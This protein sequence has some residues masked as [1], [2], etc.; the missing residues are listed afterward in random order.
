MADRIIEIS[1]V[2]LPSSVGALIGAERRLDE[3]ES[4]SG[5]VTAGP[6]VLLRPGLYEAAVEYALDAPDHA[7]DSAFD[8]TSAPPERRVIATGVLAPTGGRT[9]KSGVQITL[10]D[11]ARIGVRTYFA[12]RGTLAIRAISFSPLEGEGTALDLGSLRRLR[13]LSDSWGFDRGVPIDRYYI[14]EFMAKH[15]G[16][17]RGK[18]LEVG[19]R[20]YTRRFGG[21]QVTGSDVLMPKTA[22]NATVEADLRSAPHVPD[23]SFDC[24]IATQVLVCID[25]FHLAL[26]TIHRILKPGGVAL[27]TLPSIQ[28]LHNAYEWPLLWGF[29]DGAARFMFGKAFGEPNSEMDVYGNILSATSFLYGLA[30]HELS[31]DELDH[32]DSDYQVIVGVRARKPDTA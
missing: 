24:V 16:D 26:A 25:E 10:T 11:E 5:H 31:R 7:P 32:R 28:R 1:A 18:V 19:D 29:S 12:G 15:C 14:A 20:Q 22:K 2:H 13:P 3:P 9:R 21:K 6:Y 4:F 27:V 8:V 23:N 30:A 17:I